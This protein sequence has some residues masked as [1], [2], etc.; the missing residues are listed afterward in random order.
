M[1]RRN[2]LGEKTVDLGRRFTAGFHYVKVSNEPGDR[3]RACRGGRE[4]VSQEGG[5]T[6]GALSP[7]PLEKCPKLPRGGIG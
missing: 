7:Q 6:E 2:T 4:M 3:G 1:D 5:G